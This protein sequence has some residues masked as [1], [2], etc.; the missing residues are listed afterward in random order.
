MKRVIRFFV[1]LFFCIPIGWYSCQSVQD[2]LEYCIEGRVDDDFYDRIN[3]LS[4]YLV[5]NEILRE[6]S[7]SEMYE[8]MIG[9]DSVSEEDFAILNAYER[10]IAS[11][12]E[13]YSIEWCCETLLDNQTK[14]SPEYRELCAGF[15]KLPEADFNIYDLHYSVKDLDNISTA[16][17]GILLV[18]FYDYIATIGYEEYGEHGDWTKKHH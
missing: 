18:M 1:I 3:S 16:V 17:K 7:I 11:L 13:T 2:H 10:Q 5:A 12:N 14:L 15:D 4:E 9:N 8:F 6:Y